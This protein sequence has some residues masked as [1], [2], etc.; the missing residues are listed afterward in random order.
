MAFEKDD[1]WVLKGELWYCTR[2]SGMTEKYVRVVKDMS[3]AV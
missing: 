1:I 3:E 2:K